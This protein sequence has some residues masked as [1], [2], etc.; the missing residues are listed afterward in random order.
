MKIA[1]LDCLSGISGNMLLGA[2]I[3]LGVGE[4]ALRGDL[5]ALGLADWDFR[6]ARVK[7]GALS[8]TLVE[9]V[10]TGS[11]PHRSLSEILSIIE[12]SP[13]PA[14]VREKA[15]EVFRRLAEA[16]A[17]AHGE[18]PEQ[19]H[20]HEVGAT[21]ALVDVVGAIAAFHRLGVEKVYCSPMPLSRGWVESSHGPLPL[22]APATAFLLR[23]VPTYGV[24][25]EAELVTP[26]GAALAVSISEAF[27]PQPGMT[28]HAIGCGAGSAEL[29]RPNFLRVF[30]GEAALPNAAG[31][32]ERL[33]LLETNID[34]MNP[35]LYESLMEGLFSAGALD[36]YLTPVIMKKSR[37]GVVISVLCDLQK[38]E[39]LCQ[40]I[41][42]ESTTLGVRVSEI[43]RRC[44]EREFQEIETRWG[45]VTIKVARA[46]GRIISAAPEYEDCRRLAKERNITVK[47]VYEEASALARL[48]T[49]EVEHRS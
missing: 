48:A 21:D 40:M 30:V 32:T 35:E 44:L 37:P 20:F 26:T 11:Q 6:I 4:E 3:E 19:I 25:G 47:E 34:D 7:R 31:G 2:L 27:G 42:A 17:K 45:K 5:A 46:K 38:K 22:P 49:R 24:E 9:V 10:V 41:F 14:A 1:Y 39:G 36:V 16:E 8:A 18:S 13:L 28:V 12:R 15:S 43:E 29:R 33:A 23:G